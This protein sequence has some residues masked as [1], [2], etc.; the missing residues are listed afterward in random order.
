M[1]TPASIR[2]RQLSKFFE[3]RNGRKAVLDSIEFDLHTGE[4]VCV[5]G[6]SGCGKS[7][8]LNIL[9]ALD[10]EYTGFLLFDG[11]PPESASMHMAYLFQEPRLL[12]WMTV[13]QNIHFALEAAHV[14]R[15]QW[16][17]RSQ[18]YLAMVG[19]SGCED[20]YIHQLSGGMQHRASISRAFA[21]EPDV[22]L[23]DEP[24]SALDELTARKLRTE[25]LD[26]W[27]AEKKTVLFVTHNTMEA[28]YM[29]D[30][31]MMMSSDPGVIEHVETIDLPRPREYDS[32]LLFD[33][34]RTVVQRFLS[35]IGEASE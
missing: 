23:M 9:S 14:P 13:E 29:A 12:P 5:L 3:N 7:T 22:L 32:E 34:H 8:I 27:A 18:K 11:K 17:H 24:F 16:K 1:T 21:V 30:R 35:I 28:T 25:L 20:Y 19:L 33:C 4:F 10:R 2:V 6:P 26:I 31:I 15:E